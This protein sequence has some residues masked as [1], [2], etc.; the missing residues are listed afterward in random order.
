MSL[1]PH[2]SIFAYIPRRLQ[3]PIAAGGAPVLRVSLP[4]L[5]HG[6]QYLLAPGHNPVREGLH[7][8][9]PALWRRGRGSD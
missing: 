7:R 3:A 1:G 4:V 5:L 6:I 9:S 2:A 8:Y